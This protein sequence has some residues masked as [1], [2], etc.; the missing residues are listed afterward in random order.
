MVFDWILSR[1]SASRHRQLTIWF[2]LLNCPD[3]TW[4]L[5]KNKS[6]F[7]F[8]CFFF[9]FFCS[10]FVSQTISQDG[11]FDVA[12]KVCLEFRL[13]SAPSRPPRLSKW[14]QFVLKKVLKKRE[15]STCQLPSRKSKVLVSGWTAAL[16]WG[17]VVSRKQVLAELVVS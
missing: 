1:V 5:N 16:K 12:K 2:L 11:H 14:G 10:F 4:R 6:R 17:H 7:S 9:F 3:H 8:C 13:V 15:S